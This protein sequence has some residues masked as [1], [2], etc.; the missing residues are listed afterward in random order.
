MAHA[1]YCCVVSRIILVQMRD[2]LHYTWDLFGC[3]LVQ[4]NHHTSQ[5]AHHHHA[6]HSPHFVAAKY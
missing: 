2:R 6:K 5:I 3:I 4:V 1:L